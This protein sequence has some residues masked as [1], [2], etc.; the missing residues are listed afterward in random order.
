MTNIDGRHTTA[1]SGNT[2]NG[3]VGSG[4][5]AVRCQFAV[6]LPN[7]DLPEI[8]IRDAMLEMFSIAGALMILSEMLQFCKF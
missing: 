5:S 4:G 3:T 8:Q 7:Y 2:Q 6:V 1:Y